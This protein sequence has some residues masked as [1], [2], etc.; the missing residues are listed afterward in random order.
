VTPAPRRRRQLIGRYYVYN[1]LYTLASSLIWGVNTLF[2][3]DAGLTVSE[4][5]IAN[6]A[7]S[8]GTTIFEIPTGVI[9]DTIGRRASF[10]ISLVVLTLSTLSYAARRRGCG[11]G[12]ACLCADGLGFTL[13]GRHE[14]WLVDGLAA[15]GY[16]GELDRVFSRDTW[17]VALRCS[18]DG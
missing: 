11:G 7:W 18:P 8:A 15:L 2:L 5:F 4:V 10:L 6:A 17:S 13:L 14:V 9:A 1:G 3:L 12:C 16:N